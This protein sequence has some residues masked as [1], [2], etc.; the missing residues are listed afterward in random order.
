MI[1]V[2][3]VSPAPAILVRAGEPIAHWERNAACD[4]W[5]LVAEWPASR[6][7]ALAEEIL[8]AAAAGRDDAESSALRMQWRSLALEDSGH[9]AR[10]AWLMPTT[11]EAAIRSDDAAAS[12]LQLVTEAT[13]V[14]AW[15]ANLESRTIAWH[16][17]LRRVLGTANREVTSV[18]AAKRL[19]ETM[20]HPDDLGQLTDGFAR[21]GRDDF[22]TGEWTVRIRRRD[23]ALRWVVMRARRVN[24]GPAREIFGVIIDVTEQR[25]ALDRLRHAER[26]AALATHEAGFGVWQRDLVTGERIWDEQMYRLRGLDPRDPRSY[27]ELSAATAHPESSSVLSDYL[28]EVMLMY[29]NGT[30]P[31]NF[32]SPLLEFR[33]IRPDGAERWLCSRGTLIREPGRNPLLLGL[34]WDITDHKHAE[35][36]RQQHAAAEEANRAKSQ[37]L[38]N[39]S[40][41]I[42]T[43]MNA[44]IGMAHLALGSGLTM[45]Q[46]NYVSKVER[47]AQSLL[48][49][50]NDILDFSK[51]EAGKLDVESV[52]FDLGN[53]MDN[54]AN[55]VG[56]NAEERGLEL[57]FVEP[58]DLPMKLVGD[59]LRLSQ[60]LVNLGNNAIK[61]TERGEVVVSIDVVE[62]DAESV[63]LR[64]SVRDTGVGMSPDQRQ[65]L[66]QPF[67]QADASTSRR[68]GGTGLGLA[69]SHHLVTLMGGRIDV[70]STIGRGSTFSL[71]LR[72][73]L[74]AAAEGAGK[75]RRNGVRAARVLIVDDNA[76]AR[77]ILS[78]MS[79][80][81]GLDVEEAKDGWEALHA[82]DI[83]ADAGNP[84]DLV[85][86]DWKMPGM[87]GVK[88]AHQLM[89]S[90]G[91]NGPLVVMTT[92]YGRDD[93][94]QRLG[95]LKVRVSDV[96]VKPVTPSTLLDTYSVALGKPA[97]TDSRTALR[98]EYLAERR[99]QL[100]GARILLVED[101]DINQE[102]AFELLNAAGLVVTVA[103]NGLQALD[104]LA[105]HE[106]DGVLMDLQMPVM[107]GYAATRA[108][109][110]QPRW[111]SLPIIAM[112]ASAMAGDREL[113][114]A[115][116]MNDHIAKPIDVVAMFEII[117]RWV[118]PS[119]RH[120]PAPVQDL[121]S[122]SAW[123]NLPGIDA[124]IGRAST[125]GKEALYRR[126]LTLF[127]E[128]QQRF[129]E[130]FKTLREA[131][132]TQ[133]A[134]SA[135]T[136]LRTLAGTLGAQ[137]VAIAAHRL[138]HA[139]E[140]AAD[141]ATIQARLEDVSREL[142]IVMGGLRSLG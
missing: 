70:R 87:D 114:L 108:I 133:A 6:W 110:A 10:L 53:V 28:E 126:L 19:M 46:H 116:G 102:L 71:S 118:R 25:E 75:V 14:S 60:V 33:I 104:T 3:R 63:L 44:I 45:Q 107:D 65:R 58:P 92:A 117:A 134:L 119:S 85:L 124:R 132:D 51:I 41:E 95:A 73:G 137:A 123:G 135:T 20:V 29:R 43:P 13:G 96:L 4:A 57:L 1:E 11:I 109:R 2:C 27:D 21:M 64:F 130:Q 101:N 50:I 26:R 136:N 129:V 105:L 8:R 17:D 98:D 97:R 47:S 100:R 76:T 122:T 90:G 7:Q 86:L 56:L 34:H 40:H 138:E 77:H 113:A 81:L 18:D 80:A 84:F 9:P 36:L 72:F 32:V 69:I 125:A 131:G 112:T 91:D 127:R 89:T 83:A 88:C 31:A 128:D 106:F 79:L 82:V 111:Q 16:G 66:F 48:G 49:L 139:C 68:Y 93:V 94:L 62:S 54:L 121:P 37:F 15:R 74:Q 115:A 120:E 35:Q 141:E 52:A 67:S 23:G 78:T 55:L 30:L 24:G 39:M 12:S 59:P 38:A 42:R 103:E 22:E 99:A 5:P 140:S 61:F 142:D